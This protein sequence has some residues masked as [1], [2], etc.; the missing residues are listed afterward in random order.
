MYVHLHCYRLYAKLKTAGKMKEG[1]AG[2]D[3]A[4]PPI[5]N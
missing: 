2:K 5:A 3:D 4:R 1:G